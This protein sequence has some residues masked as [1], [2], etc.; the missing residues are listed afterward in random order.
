MNFNTE[1]KDR[2]NKEDLT[3]DDHYCGMTF[4]GDPTRDVFGVYDGFVRTT[5]ARAATHSGRLRAGA[6]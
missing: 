4:R 3:V 6:L 2:L 5:A 1:K